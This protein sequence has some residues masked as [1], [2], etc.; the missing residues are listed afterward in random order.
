MHL[1][2]SFLFMYQSD[3]TT[4]KHCPAAAGSCSVVILFGKVQLRFNFLTAF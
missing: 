1:D 2:A 3:I 4:I